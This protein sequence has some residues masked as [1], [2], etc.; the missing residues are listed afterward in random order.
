LPEKGF[1]KL[2]VVSHNPTS[3]ELYFSDENAATNLNRSVVL[4]LFLVSW[5]A[6]LA[7]GLSDDAQAPP[8]YKITARLPLSQA[9]SGIDGY[10]ELRQDARLTPEL[11]GL[12]WGTGDINIDDD[13]KLAAFK[14]DPLHNGAIQV[15]D[16][17]G[18]VLEVKTLERP[19]AKLRT[20]QLYGDAKLTYLLTVDYSAGFGS[21][22]GP[23]TSLV[24]VKGGHLRWLEST[25]PATGRTGEI[26]L[27][28][29]LK[30]TWRL[31]DAQDGKG[32]QILLAQC[33]PDRSSVKHDPDFTTQY[34]RIYFDGSKWLAK[35]RTVKGLS[36]FDQGFPER[37]N[38]P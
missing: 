29:S 24:E 13:P 16:R 28:E 11:I 18:K 22:S 1:R 20:A 8:Q 38:F 34:A 27:M 25:E 3:R 15:V 30:T 2:D 32:K 23:I 36:E 6:C 19:L 26:S 5:G 33:R 21:Y 4:G 37:K 9:S 12:L 14:N 35:V 7:Y 10:L 31:V 17:A